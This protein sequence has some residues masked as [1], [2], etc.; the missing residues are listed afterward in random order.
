MAVCALALVSCGARAA[1]SSHSSWRP[2]TASASPATPAQGPDTPSPSSESQQARGVVRG[3]VV[4][5]PGSDPRSG[6]N[7]GSTPV[8]VNGDPVQAYDLGGR[9]IAT[10]VTQSGGYFSIAL[11][12]GGYQITEGTC[13]VSKQVN[14]KSGSSTY[15]VLT[16][17][18]AC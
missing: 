9:V 5:P 4:R 17:P 11:P 7:S 18:N 8:P 14:V 10:A 1:V 13:G 12:P 15:L 2:T 3:Q 6:G 16:I